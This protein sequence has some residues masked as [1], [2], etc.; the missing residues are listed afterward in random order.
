VHASRAL[1]L[2]PTP[3]ADTP[4]LR[5]PRGTMSNRQDDRCTPSRVLTCTKPHA[6][7]KTK[8]ESF[9][10]FQQHGCSMVVMVQHGPSQPAAAAHGDKACTG[11]RLIAGATQ[12]TPPPHT[13]ELQ[14][15][16]HCLKA[17][18]THARTA[19]S[20]NCATG[21]CMLLK[22]MTSSLGSRL[23]HQLPASSRIE[24]WT[25]CSAAYSNPS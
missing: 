14:E 6:G 9:F 12:P 16:L 23:T 18:F 3:A 11:M 1:L 7:W 8:V 24:S 4:G 2:S 21:H 22:P 5:P 20:R 17:I 19:L 15:H 13:Q 10:L 25:R